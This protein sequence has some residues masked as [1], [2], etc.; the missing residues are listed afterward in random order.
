M[1]YNHIKEVFLLLLI[2]FKRKVLSYGILKSKFVKIMI[3]SLVLLYLGGFAFLTFKF[4]ENVDSSVK[5]SSIVLD[6]FS[7][8]IALWTVVGF[9]FMKMLFIKKRNFLNFLVTLPVL[10]REIKL[11]TLLFEIVMVLIGIQFIATGVSIALVLRH[12][13][14]F[15]PR[16]ICNIYFQSTFIYLVL[17]AVYSLIS[18]FIDWLGI[19]KIKILILISFLSIGCILVYTRIYSD[20]VDKLLFDYID[21]K[22]TSI[23]VPFAFLLDKSG[24]GITFLIF[25]LI[26][27]VVVC[28]ICFIPDNQNDYMANYLKFISIK[29]ISL[30]QSYSANCLRNTDNINYII[31]ALLIY[32]VLMFNKTQ[33]AYCSFLILGVNSI[34]FYIQTNE[35]RL[36]YLQKEYNIFKDYIILLYSQIKYITAVSLPFVLIN[37]ILHFDI[38][39]ILLFYL[40][41]LSGT[42][43]FLMVGILFPP[44]YENPFSVILGMFVTLM[45]LVAIFL[46]LFFFTGNPLIESIV[47]VI[48]NLICILFSIIG[49]KRLNETLKMS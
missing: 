32:I 8:T 18:W 19:Y 39:G 48:I 40:I 24:L 30:Q 22:T 35:I 14:G 31:L 3:L 12:G 20:L 36:L 7:L 42:I 41:L 34:Y 11:A 2:F 37:N 13:I 23:I 4:F 26:T 5:Q 43:L 15:L 47:T 21:N 28:V 46:I 45:V 16:I 27:L 6:I 9:I 17:E 49:M 1:K 38:K 10:Q 25:L 29:K 33:Y 44:K